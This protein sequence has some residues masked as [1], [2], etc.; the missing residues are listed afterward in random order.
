MFFIDIG[1]RR[2]FDPEINNIDN[3]YLSVVPGFFDQW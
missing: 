3:A 1:D 2:N